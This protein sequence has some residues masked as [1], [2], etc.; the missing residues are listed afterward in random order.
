MNPRAVEAGRLLFF[1]PILSGNKNIACATC[2]HPDLGTSDGLS[3]GLGEGGTGLGPERSAEGGNTRVRKRI[4]RNAPGL[5]N[6]G[7]REI[8]ILLH[9]GRVSISDLHGNG[10][11]TP[12]AEDLPM[13]LSDVLAAQAL[14]P[15]ISEFEMAGKR[16]DNDVAK[17]ARR[18]PEEGWERIAHRIRIIPEYAGLLR[19]AFPDLADGG[20]I[21]IRHV[22]N[23]LSAFVNWEFRSFDS[24]YDQYL[25]GDS[26]ALNASEARGM[27]L[28]FGKAGC[29]ACHGGRLLSDQEF[30]AL[31]LPHLGPGRTRLFDPYARDVGRMA[32]TDH[33]GDAYR[34]R[35]PML[36]NVALTAP[37]GHNGAYRDLRGILSHHLDPIPAL[38]AWRP[39]NAVLP[40]AEW[41]SATDFLI[42]DDHREMERLRAR[43]DIRPVS[44]GEHEI[45][46]LVA[47]LHA[48][49]GG[50]SVRGRL[51]IPERV[52]SGLPLDR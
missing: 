17:A 30:H 36:R 2:H 51:G 42:F 8:R 48:L 22:A 29:S 32:E 5:W 41:L 37:Y 11:D 24:R 50:E 39:E 12:T 46:D 31:A 28:F 43:L 47:F 35:T 52:P 4:P 49:T 15:L 40:E 27:G 19:D 21:E 3:L 7:A 9:D 14:L 23:A 33:I 25:A 44:L 6:L 18:R 38:A 45:D 20:Q 16:E 26:D 34:F 1:D 10:F 13:G